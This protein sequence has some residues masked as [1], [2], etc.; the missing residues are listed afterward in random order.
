MKTLYYLCSIMF[1]FI[2]LPLSSKLCWYNPPRPILST[3]AEAVETIQGDMPPVVFS[4]CSWTSCSYV[5]EWYNYYTCFIHT[6]YDA[7]RKSRVKYHAVFMQHN[8]IGLPTLE[9]VKRE[10]N[11]TLNEQFLPS[12][13]KNWSGNKTKGILHYGK[14]H[15]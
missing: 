5:V 15:Y 9:Q 10:W 3:P 14:L 1:T 12:M 6:V 4:G 2:W 8:L 7:H 13:C 11:R